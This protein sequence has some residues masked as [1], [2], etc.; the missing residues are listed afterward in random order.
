MCFC[1]LF[2]IMKLLQLIPMKGRVKKLGG[3][4]AEELKAQIDGLGLRLLRLPVLQALRIVV[5]IPL[6]FLGQ[7]CGFE[8]CSS[9]IPCSSRVW[10][11]FFAF[12]SWCL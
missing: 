4:P 1:Y 8:L 11:S 7:G 3:S 2:F 10:V 9:V 6:N 12:A 5:L